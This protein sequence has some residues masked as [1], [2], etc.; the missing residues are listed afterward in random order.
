MP[1]VNLRQLELPRLELRLDVLDKVQ[2]G[3]FGL[4]IVGVAGHGDIALGGFLVQRG[5]QLAPIQQP[6]FQLGGGAAL[7]PPSLQRCR[8][9]V[10]SAP[11]SPN[12]FP[13]AQTGAPG[14]RVTSLNGNKSMAERYPKPANWKR[15]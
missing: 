10:Q 5:A 7:R 3:L 1:D 9:A 11:N 13:A 15:D 14:A 12:Q 6:A 2:V 8:R 4:G